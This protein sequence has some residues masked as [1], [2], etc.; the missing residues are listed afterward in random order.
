M[1]QITY[2]LLIV[3]A[4]AYNIC[5]I[6]FD[7]FTNKLLFVVDIFVLVITLAGSF[8]QFLDE[9]EFEVKWMLWYIMPTSLLVVGML[10]NYQ[11][12]S[13][14]ALKLAHI[15]PAPIH[16]PG[17]AGDYENAAWSHLYMMVYPFCAK[18]IAV[19]AEALFTWV[20]PNQSSKRTR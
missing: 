7:F 4:V 6:T 14:N 17:H 10:A 11:D 5:Q 19:M 8:L 13:V 16:I 15:K 12:I 1:G 9:E 20:R 3:I 18:L 2:A